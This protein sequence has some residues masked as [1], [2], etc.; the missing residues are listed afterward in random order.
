M[1]P[2]ESKILVAEDMNSF[3]EVITEL[4][5]SLGFNN[6]KACKNGSQAWEL[7]ENEEPGFDLVI[8]DAQMPHSSGVDLLKRIRSSQRYQGL[9]FLMIS[10]HSE[11]K[12][13]VAAVKAGADYYLVKPFKAEELAAKLQIIFDRK[14]GLG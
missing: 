8:S 13:V 5:Q 7:I 3:R 14:A 6:I 2:A 4:L 9:P 11:E 10:A 1:F 12:N